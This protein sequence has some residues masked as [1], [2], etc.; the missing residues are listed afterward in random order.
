MTALEIEYGLRKKYP[1][2]RRHLQE[3]ATLCLAP[4]RRVF[5]R[6]MVRLAR[7][8]HGCEGQV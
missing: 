4:Q 8:S 3:V 6:G 5:L 7:H 1:S 2:R